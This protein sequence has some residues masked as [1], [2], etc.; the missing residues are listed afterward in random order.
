METEDQSD[1]ID[2]A[3]DFAKLLSGAEQDQPV[4]E[5]EA[6]S[7]EDDIQDETDQPDEESESP[8]DQ[9]A[10]QSDEEL[11][12]EQDGQKVKAKKTELIKAFVD[13]ESMQRDYTQKTQ[14]LAEEYRAAQDTARME[15]QFVN[16][17]A[18][19]VSQMMQLSSQVQ[20]YERLD[21]QSLAREDPQMYAARLAEF[22]EIKQQARDA[23]TNVAQKRSAYMQMPLQQ[24]TQSQAE[25]WDHMGKVDKTFNKDRLVK[26]FEDAREFGFDPRELNAITDKRL[27]HMWSAL[28]KKAAAYDEIVKK[29]PQMQQ[30][31][32]SVPTKVNRATGKPASRQEQLMNRVQKGNIGRND[33]AMLLASTRK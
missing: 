18:G 20:A 33:F 26:M 13:R 9:A 17:F 2:N 22:T 11:E 12:F 24:A 1:G 23:A 4:A 3:G 30:R 21:W 27:V 16:Q 7:S 15:F 31:L 28:H 29:Q 5:S 25:V 14:R 10:A 32:A 6:A 8:E 19:E